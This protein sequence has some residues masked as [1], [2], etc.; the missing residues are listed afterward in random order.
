VEAVNGVHV[1]RYCAALAATRVLSLQG[2]RSAC[3]LRLQ[4]ETLNHAYPVDG[5]A[6]AAR[7]FSVSGHSAHSLTA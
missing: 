5:Q 7:H 1:E 4:K 2:T 6:R 3:Y